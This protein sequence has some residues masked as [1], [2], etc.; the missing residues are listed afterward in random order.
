MESFCIPQCDG[1]HPASP[2]YRQASKILPN[3]KNDKRVKKIDNL[4]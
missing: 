2:T 4:F 1:F 3:L